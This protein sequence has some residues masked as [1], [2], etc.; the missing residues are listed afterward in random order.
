VNYSELAADGRFKNLGLVAII[1]AVI[2][3]WVLLKTWP[4]GK[5]KSISQH[6][7][8]RATTFW[9]FMAIL[10]VDNLL[11]LA[12]IWKWFVPELGLM[13]GFGLLFTV[14]FLLQ[15]AA[16][17]IPDRGDGSKTSKRHGLAAFS[18][19]G[20]MPL[21]TL[22]LALSPNVGTIPRILSALATAWMFFSF[23]LFLFVPRSRNHFL[24]FQTIY[25]ASFY[26]CI[27]ASTYLRE[28][29]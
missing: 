24:T 6:L 20:I 18:M 1:I 3:A 14:G 17:L 22:W 19:A 9:I 28:M 8:A 29:L 12:F 23:Y 27:L 16:A 7:G 4:A 5:H 21:L 26:V 10:I 2:S 15:V 13:P 11:L 25:I